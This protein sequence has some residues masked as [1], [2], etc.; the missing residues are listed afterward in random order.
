VDVNVT[1]KVGK[2][3]NKYSQVAPGIFVYENVIDNP[4]ELIDF[5]LT[6]GEAWRESKVSNTSS[7]GEIDKNIR[8]TRALDV[9]GTF[10]N[11]VKWFEV[12]QKIWQYANSYA[13]GFNIGFSGMELAQLLHYSAG[14]SFYKPHSDSGPNNP[15]I[16]SALLYLN[17]V[18]KG[19]ETYF[20]YFDVSISPKAGRLVIFPAD[21]IYMHEA[22]PP[23]SN[24]KFAIVTW[25]TPII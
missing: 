1:R 10:L 3:L 12:S 21:Y 20:N 18:D 19:G 23:I 5:S 6:Y 13:L 8:N 15:R 4:Q 25:F 9:G 17:D 11:D 2:M 14:E 22:K 24:D 16:F 7:E